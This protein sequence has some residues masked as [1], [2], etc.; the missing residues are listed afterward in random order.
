M[1]ADQANTLINLLS[2]LYLAARVL[3][4]LGALTF[5]GLTFLAYKLG[6]KP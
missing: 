1:T 4:I 3:I 5:G 2:Q 6:R